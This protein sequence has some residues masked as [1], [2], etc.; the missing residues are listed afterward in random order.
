MKRIFVCLVLVLLLALPVF[1]ASGDSKGVAML[2][3]VLKD[4]IGFYFMDNAGFM[5]LSELCDP[6]GPYRAFSFS[7]VEMYGD[8]EPVVVVN[9]GDQ[10]LL[11][12]YDD[13]EL[14]YGW[15][16]DS[17]AMQ[18]IRKNGVF[19]AS[20]GASVGEYCRLAFDNLQYEVVILAEYDEEEGKY[21]L[22]GKVV[23]KE[24]FDAFIEDLPGFAEEFELTDENI[25]KW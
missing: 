19:H 16:F 12:Y 1:A 15:L 5:T 8:G 4:E 10:L 2:K 14:V 21:V 6:E 7:V 20:G 3:E 23:S 24:E 9:V 22:M 11:R 18:M 13:T 17:R 25:E